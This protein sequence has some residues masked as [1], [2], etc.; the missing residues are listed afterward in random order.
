MAISLTVSIITSDDRGT[1][2]RTIE[3]I[4]VPLNGWNLH[5]S[6]A[7]TSE[8]VD[9]IVFHSPD[10]DQILRDAEER[11]RRDILDEFRKLTLGQIS[12]L[13]SPSEYE[14]AD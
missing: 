2:K 14:Y 3:Q 12:E 4:S 11:G 10:L 13:L 6:R 5:W 9:E 8:S 1:S 7:L